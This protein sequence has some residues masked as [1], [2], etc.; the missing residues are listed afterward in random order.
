MLP[1]LLPILRAHYFQRH[2]SLVL[3]F[4]L[5]FFPSPLPASCFSPSTPPTLP[6][7]PLSS[8]NAWDLGWYLL[9]L[10]LHRSPSHPWWHHSC[11][12]AVPVLFKCLLHLMLKHFSTQMISFTA[13]MQTPWAG[14]LCSLHAHLRMKQPPHP[15]NS[16]LSAP[17]LFLQHL[18]SRSK[19]CA[20]PLTPPSL[21]MPSSVHPNSST[22][23]QGR[24]SASSLP[25]HM[26]ECPVCLLSSL[27][28]VGVF[29]LPPL[30]PHTH[31]SVLFALWISDTHLGFESFSFL[32]GFWIE[33]LRMEWKWKKK[34]EVKVKT[35]VLI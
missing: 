10:G 32:C 11:T 13:Q 19:H 2:L 33:L 9:L 14:L 3:F 7:H 26:W 6:P 23:P 16:C 17:A 15:A 27:V 34:D 12:F 20:Q 8:E 31:W 30:L 1:F 29:Y 35:E 22:L 4:P 18:S 24:S 5:P 21:E 25:S 28:Q